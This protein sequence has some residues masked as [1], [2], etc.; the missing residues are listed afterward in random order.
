MSVDRT[1]GLLVPDDAYPYLQMQRGAISDM[2]GDQA[3]WLQHYTDAVFSEFDSIEPYLPKRCDS[4]LDVGSGLGGI[5]ALLN[6]HYGGECQVTLLDGVDDKP[7]MESHAKTF[8]HMGIAKKFL[9][10]NGVKQIDYIDAN[11]RTWAA[12]RFFDLIVSFKSWCF[13]YEPARYLDLVINASISK[14]TTIIV[15][16]RRD[17]P[18]WL[19]ELRE[20]F[21][22][23]DTIYMGSK[24]YCVVLQAR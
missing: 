23:L 24:F 8:N 19:T 9:G 6:R 15:D 20:E 3:V 11:S 12:P 10:I 16:V 14:Q 5:D 7:M 18:Q 2:R 4:I 22:F 21:T 17:K 1:L 13:H